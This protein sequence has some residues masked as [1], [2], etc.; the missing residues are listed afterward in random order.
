MKFTLQCQQFNTQFLENIENAGDTKNYNEINE[1]FKTQNNEIS[2]M[3][4]KQI[5]GIKD[6]KP[7]LISLE[8]VHKQNSAL[9]EPIQHLTDEVNNIFHE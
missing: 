2:N 8:N 9:L 5:D 1:N 6:I 4:T 7:C 3:F